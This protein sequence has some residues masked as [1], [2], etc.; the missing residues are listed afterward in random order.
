M[1]PSRN[2]LDGLCVLIWDI[3]IRTCVRVLIL[4]VSSCAGGGG[5]WL[6]KKRRWK[7]EEMVWSI[8]RDNKQLDSRHYITLFPSATHHPGEPRLLLPVDRHIQPSIR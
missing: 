7:S 8:H 1:Q 2:G 3:L 4:T 5:G 6:A